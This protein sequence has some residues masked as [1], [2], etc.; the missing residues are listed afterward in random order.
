MCERGGELVTTDESAVVTETFLDAI[1]VEDGQ[2]GAGLANPA[3]TDESDRSEV[4]CQT[5]DLLNQVAT[6]KVAPRWRRRR[7]SGYAGCE[8]KPRNPSV[9]KAADLFWI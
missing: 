2:S 5:N 7:F 3:D 6:S 1:V 4:F 8:H 9:V